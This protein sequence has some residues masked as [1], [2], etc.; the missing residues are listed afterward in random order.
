MEKRTVPTWFLFLFYLFTGIVFFSCR[1]DQKKE[2][3]GGDSTNDTISVKASEDVVD[4]NFPSALQI[5]CLFKNS[6]LQYIEGITSPPKDPAAF[7]SNYSKSLNL[8]IYGADLAYCVLN[9]QD[10]ETMN[11]V[12]VFTD[13]AT[14]LGMNRV[15][16]RGN[17]VRRFEKNL[18]HEDSL[19]DI[20]A[21][22]QIETDTYLRDNEEQHIS[23]ISFSG[24][25]TEIMFLGSKSFEKSK[26]SGLSDKISEQMNILSKIISVL[27]AD[28][29]KDPGIPPLLAE[30][31]RLLTFYNGF[32]SV[33]KS[34][35]EIKEENMGVIVSLNEQEINMLIGKITELRNKLMKS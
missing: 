33:K 9:Q 20:I 6:G 16:E 17:F 19:R 31:K 29:K 5:A 15:Y 23:A 28:E 21:E 7:T 13:I 4:Y 8:G 12:K 2:V 22:L 27:K 35:A 14:S 32:E 11:Y 18:N 25:W 1:N 10:Q 34:R 26:G 30:M 3:S 24:A